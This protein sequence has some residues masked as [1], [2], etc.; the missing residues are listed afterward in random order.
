MGRFLIRWIQRIVRQ[1]IRRSSADVGV[2]QF[3]DSLLKFVLY[4]LLLFIIIQ[5]LGVPSA[6]IAAVIA[7]A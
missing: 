6:S 3:I 5:N 1:S 2:E 7:S 4:T